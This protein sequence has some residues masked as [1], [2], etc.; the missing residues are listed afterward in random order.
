M[1]FFFIVHKY[2]HLQRLLK[3]E[4]K[5]ILPLFFIYF[6]VG[7]RQERRMKERRKPAHSLG[8]V[9]KWTRP[10]R[11]PIMP[12][13]CHLHLPV[14]SPSGC[15]VQKCQVWDI[16][17]YRPWLYEK[18]VA[19]DKFLQ[20]NTTQWSTIRKQTTVEN[21][22]ELY[23]LAPINLIERNLGSSCIEEQPCKDLGDLAH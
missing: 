14:W 7:S 19:T 2:L 10:E 1:H 4:T 12:C 3:V 17:H 18:E 21:M 8:G 6:L 22:P 11:D 23:Q 16:S 5:Q 20:A 15:A 9:Y 13:G